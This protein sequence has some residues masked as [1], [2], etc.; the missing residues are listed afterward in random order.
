MGIVLA[1]QYSRPGDERQAVGKSCVEEA[2]PPTKAEELQG[3]AS[4]H[5]AS[6][7]VGTD[8]FHPDVPPDLGS[9]TSWQIVEFL[10]KVK[11]CGY[12]Q[13]RPAHTYS[14]F[15][16]KSQRRTDCPV[17]Y[18]YSM[19]GMVEITSHSRMKEHE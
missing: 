16:R 2:L 19:V 10:A 12:C 13:F 8:D 3:A 7:G 5:K 4:S 15:Q 6:T 18:A 9:N 17:A 11:Q 1:G 14:F